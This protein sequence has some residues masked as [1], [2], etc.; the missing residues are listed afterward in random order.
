M[1]KVESVNC[2]HSVY[3]DYPKSSMNHF[4]WVIRLI[5]WQWELFVET[6]EIIIGY[7]LMKIDSFFCTGIEV[8]LQINEFRLNTSELYSLENRA[9][10]VKQGFN[11]TSW[12]KNHGIIS[13]IVCVCILSNAQWKVSFAIC[14]NAAICGAKNSFSWFR[15]SPVTSG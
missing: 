14:A 3:D 12:A 7:I 11:R 8:F 13:G 15:T 2:S 5:T 4:R 1:S 9:E 10:L 6:R